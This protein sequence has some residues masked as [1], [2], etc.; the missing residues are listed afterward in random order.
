MP[1]SPALFLALMG[2]VAASGFLIGFRFRRMDKP[3]G[4][5]TVEQVN[6]FGLVLMIANPIFFLLI[7]GLVLSGAIGPLYGPVWLQ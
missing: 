2:F 3:L 1:I 6:R 4:T 7:C 5:S